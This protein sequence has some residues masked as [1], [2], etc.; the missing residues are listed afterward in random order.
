[1]Y[2]TTEQACGRLLG[3]W[4]AGARFATRQHLG[5]S[6]TV[7]MDPLEGGWAPWSWEGG[8]LVPGC[9]V[10]RWCWPPGAS[11]PTQCML[12]E[13]GPGVLL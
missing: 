11:G 1:M 9:G 4:W 6:A 7:P 5:M 8:G 12:S 2:K 10:Y 3:Q 13:G